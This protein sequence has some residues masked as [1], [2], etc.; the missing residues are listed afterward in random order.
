MSS[1]RV[2]SYVIT[3]CGL[4]CDHVVWTLMWPRRVDSYVIT[5]C[6]LLC[7]H[8]VWTLMSSR[9]V[10]SYVITSCGLL[11]HH[12]VWTLMSSRRVDSY[13]TT[14]TGRHACHEPASHAQSTVMQKYHCQMIQQKQQIQTEIGTQKYWNYRSV[15]KHVDESKRCRLVKGTTTIKSRS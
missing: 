2:D 4:L 1:H 13:V 8:V 11:C 15:F 12:V 10:D 14:R 5:P 3:S 7:D 9:R 6:G